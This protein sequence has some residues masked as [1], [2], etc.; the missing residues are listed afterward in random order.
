MATILQDDPSPKAYTKDW[1]TKY[2][3]FIYTHLSK[4]IKD[5][6]H[7]YGMVDGP[8]MSV[9]V[10]AVTHDLI[11][12]A[13]SYEE[14]E[15]LGDNILHS[16]FN[17]YIM[18]RFPN[19]KKDA[20]SELNH[21]YMSEQYQPTLTKKMGLEE[22]LRAPET[23][24]KIREDLFESFFGG[25]YE[26]S[27][28]KANEGRAFVNCLNMITVLF[29]DVDITPGITAPKTTVIQNVNRLGYGEIIRKWLDAEGT[30]I[31]GNEKKIK[32]KGADGKHRLQLVI[33]HNA[34]YYLG[35][36]GIKIDSS[37]GPFV[38][39]NKKAVEREAYTAVYQHMLK[40]G[41]TKDWVDNDVRERHGTDDPRIKS[42][43]PE[44]MEEVRRQGFDD[45]RLEIITPKDDDT[46]AYVSLKLVK[47]QPLSI[48]IAGN[49]RYT[50]TQ[51]DNVNM[52]QEARAKED[53]INRFIAK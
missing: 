24:E 5:P 41:L 9:W 20:I 3:L 18:K 32:T 39:E 30:R 27:R 14:L 34:V 1:L 43:N 45:F 12:P 47:R 6:K 33:P 26:V 13:E 4:I 21:Y 29:N 11:N 40:A 50:L 46:Y 8:A 16:V 31:Y 53:L 28:I 23:N 51:D 10:R 22:W 2:Q 36:K 25:L 35:T 48:K 19:Y 42:L 52:Q 49:V 17:I 7:L 38:N 37:F 15:I 44:I